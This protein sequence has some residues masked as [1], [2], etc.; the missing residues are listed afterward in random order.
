MK[1]SM[2]HLYLPY[3]ELLQN[4]IPEPPTL[5]DVKANVICIPWRYLHALHST[6]G[7]KID[8]E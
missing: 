7:I 2:T 5:I 1:G 4:G 6:V 8:M 3:D